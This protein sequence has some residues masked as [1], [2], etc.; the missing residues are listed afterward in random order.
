VNAREV[1]LGESVPMPTV[2]E[3]LMKALRKGV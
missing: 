3:P 2:A 1:L